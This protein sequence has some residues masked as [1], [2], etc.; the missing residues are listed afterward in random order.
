MEGTILVNDQRYFL[1]NEVCIIEEITER[2]S[3]DRIDFD[4]CVD[5][6]PR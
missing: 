1:K 5:Q 6:G 3:D 4:F 2:S